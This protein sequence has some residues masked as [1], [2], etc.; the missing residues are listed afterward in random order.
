MNF[1]TEV[2]SIFY[3]NWCLTMVRENFQIYG[4]QITRKKIASQKI[5]SAY[6]P[7]VKCLLKFLSSSPSGGKL[8]IPKAKIFSK[9]Y[10]FHNRKRREETTASSFLQLSIK[11]LQFQTNHVFD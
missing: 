6:A 1:V 8:L 3:E 5:E 9:I 7:P 10:F 4:V 11:L 2:S